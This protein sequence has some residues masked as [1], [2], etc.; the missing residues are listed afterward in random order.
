MISDPFF[1]FNTYCSNFFN[2][3]FMFFMPLGFSGNLRFP[4][5]LL[6]ILSLGNF[7]V[8]AQ[9]APRVDSLDDYKLDDI[10]ERF[11]SV[12]N[13]LDRLERMLDEFGPSPA[14][15]APPAASGD[16]VQPCWVKAPVG[17][18]GQHE[19]PPHDFGRPEHFLAG[20]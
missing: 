3:I 10:Q 7:S 14:T 12:R 13:K 15:A 18:R 2:L 16:S 19:Y 4:S 9:V 1:Y 11:R 17:G 8:S 6:L 20:W 5:F